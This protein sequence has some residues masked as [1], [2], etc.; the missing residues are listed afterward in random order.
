MLNESNTTKNN[1]TELR[2]QLTDMLTVAN[3]HLSFDA[4][5]KEFPKDKAGVP[6]ENHPHTAWELLEHLKI[7]QWDILEFSRD[8]EFVS[9]KFPDGYWPKESTPPSKTAWEKSV[10][11]FNHDLKEMVDLINDKNIDLYQKFPYGDGQNLLRE[12]LVLAK[13]NSYHLG[14]LALLK[15]AL[16]G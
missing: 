4:V 15:K 8:A 1:V 11:K 9:P 12:A 16:V 14:Q 2:K 6:V 5:M 3:A 7:C 10:T 13:H